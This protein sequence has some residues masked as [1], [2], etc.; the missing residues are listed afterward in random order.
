MLQRSG[1]AAGPGRRTVLATLAGLPLVGGCVAPILKGL[2]W[3]S[4]EEDRLAGRTSAVTSATIKAFDFSSLKDLKGQIPRAR[5]GKVELSRLILG[6]NLIGGWAHARDLIYVSSLVKAYHTRQKVYETFMLA[7]KCGVN[8]FLT[9]P[10]LCGIINDYWRQRVGRIQFI[11]DCAAGDLMTGIKQSIDGGACACYI[12]GGIG[13][14][15]VRRK[16]FDQIANALEFIRKNGQPAGMGAHKLA[17]VQGCVAQGIKPDFWMKTLHHNRYWSAQIQQECDNTWCENA[18]ATIAFMKDLPE[19]WIAYK[20]LA[21]GAIQPADG[22]RYAL[23]HGADFLC[24]GMYDFQMVEDANIA[25][26]ALAEHQKRE[27]PWRA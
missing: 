11:S 21:A 9:N 16:Q 19:P 24:V 23:Q 12:Q 15:M 14:E 17:T 7:E 20:I 4:H 3:R 5:I 18:E 1:S 22:F 27:R 13:D 2:G 25:L 10:A 8:T 6:G 26:E